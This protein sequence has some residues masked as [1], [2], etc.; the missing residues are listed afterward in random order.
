MC[1]TNIAIMDLVSGCPDARAGVRIIPLGQPNFDTHTPSLVATSVVNEGVPPVT[2]ILVGRT[3]VQYTAYG[4]SESKYSK[5][6]KMRVG[7]VQS[8]DVARVTGTACRQ[9][10][11]LM[12]KE[13]DTCQVSQPHTQF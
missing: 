11:Y 2:P 5:L 13:K 8:Q 3:L 6:C 7:Y 1:P 9:P 4:E 12:P 10:Q